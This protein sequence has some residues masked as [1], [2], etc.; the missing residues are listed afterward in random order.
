LAPLYAYVRRRGCDAHAAEDLTQA[1][2]GKL[3]TEDTLTVADSERGRF[4]NFLLGCLRSFLANE[5]DKARAEKR[6]GH[7]AIVSI[8]R[9]VAERRYRIEPVSARSTATVLALSDRSEDLVVGGG[10]ANRYCALQFMHGLNRVSSWLMHSLGAHA[11]Q[12]TG[13]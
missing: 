13:R 4:R 12:E 2:F 11:F 9:L 10:I 7:V 6:G 5:W 8:D 3:L 1:F